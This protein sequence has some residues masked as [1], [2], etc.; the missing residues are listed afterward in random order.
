MNVQELQKLQVEAIERQ[1]VEK[2]E[3]DLRREEGDRLARIDAYNLGR[4]HA[5]GGFGG[6]WGLSPAKVSKAIEE[7]A[8]SGDSFIVF[9]AYE[10]PV[11]MRYC[12]P[13]QPRAVLDIPGG[14]VVEYRRGYEGVILGALESSGVQA[15]FCWEEPSCWGGVDEGRRLKVWWSGG[16]PS[17]WRSEDRGARDDFSLSDC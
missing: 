8:K 15:A 1:R 5:E 9:R 11:Q 17:F 14:H 4:R 13:S 16:E 2:I 6:V 10:L 7:A 3:S 12:W